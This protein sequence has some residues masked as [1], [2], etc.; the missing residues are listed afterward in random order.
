MKLA[1]LSVFLALPACGTVSQYQVMQGIAIGLDSSANAAR[2]MDQS[3]KGAA[4][5][6]DYKTKRDKAVLAIKGVSDAL[7]VGCSA[8]V[9]DGLAQAAAAAGQEFSDLSSFVK[10][11]S[12]PPVGAALDA[13]AILGLVSGGLGALVQLATGAVAIY[14]AVQAAKLQDAAAAQAACAKAVAQFQTDM[15]ALPGSLAAQD[16]AQQP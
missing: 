15:A 8:N 13:T 11:M 1:L 14:Q 6:L 2:V 9:S 4:R 7:P 10:L 5:S 3:V 12:T 16:Q